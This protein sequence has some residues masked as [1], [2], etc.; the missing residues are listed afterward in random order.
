MSALNGSIIRSKFHSIPEPAN[1]EI[2]TSALVAEML[3]KDAP[4][5]L[6]T[7]IGGYGILA[8]F[9]GKKEGRSV[10]F[11][12]EL[13]AVPTS[14]GVEHL[15]GHDGH[16]AILLSL[17]SEIA[18]RNFP[19]SVWLIFQPA[20]ENGQGAERV[21][22]QMRNMGILP[23]F[24]IALHNNPN[25][26]EGE[27]ILHYGT[28]APASTGVEIKLYGSPSHAAFPE[29]ANSPFGAMLE[30]V[31]SHSDSV[32]AISKSHTGVKTTLINFQL[33][34][35]N[36]GVTP[37]EG[38]LRFT[39]RADK[40]H[41]LNDMCSLLERIVSSISMEHN[42]EYSIF[43]CDYFPATVN[44]EGLNNLLYLCSSDLGLK[45]VIA[46]ST[47]GGSDDFAHFSSISKCLFFDIGNGM[48]EEIHRP[49]Y[50]FNDNLIPVGVNLLKSLIREISK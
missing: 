13:D 20:E 32:T 44:D 4:D 18:D 47:T 46:E 15:C 14:E 48:G 30:I 31:N 26:N 5:L 45:T 17:A 7:N 39:L 43:Y 42:L 12:C 36:Y 21:T 8:C 50:K 22:G 16:I 40:D 10:M 9:K 3:G 49:G 24:A 41:V 23:D 34:D 25:Y 38:S 33:G 2:K 29:K 35:I 11:R 6:Y 19:G 27:I 1:G 28:Y 37:G